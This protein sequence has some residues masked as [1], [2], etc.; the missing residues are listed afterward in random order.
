MR[1]VFEKHELNRD[2]N[3]ES[4]FLDLDKL[5]KEQIRA[6]L[7]FIRLW[8]E[9]LIKIGN[10]DKVLEILNNE[11]TFC[12]KTFHY[13]TCSEDL[14]VEA[15]SYILSILNRSMLAEIQRIDRECKEPLMKYVREEIIGSTLDQKALKEKLFDVNLMCSSFKSGLKRL[16]HVFDIDVKFCDRFFKGIEKVSKYQVMSSVQKLL[17]NMADKNYTRVAFNVLCKSQAIELDHKFMIFI[18]MEYI[19]VKRPQF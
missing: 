1:S 6:Y 3:L 13:V 17:D 12:K 2:Y 18:P 16:E 7:N 15:F 4:Y 19:K 9:E 5:L 10:Y 14:H 8:C 11:W